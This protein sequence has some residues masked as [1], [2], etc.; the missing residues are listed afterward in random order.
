[1]SMTSIEM[2]RKL[3]E[4]FSEDH[5]QTHFDRDKDTFRIEWKDTEQGVTISLPGLISKWENRKEKALDEIEA[6]I[7]EALRIM[8]EKQQLEGKESKFFPSFVQVLSRQS[9]KLERS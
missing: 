1:M 3:R 7:R 8:S 6:H 9:Q 4:R 2:K 5:W